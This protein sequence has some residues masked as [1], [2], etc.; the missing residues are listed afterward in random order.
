MQLE[1]ATEIGD[2]GEMCAVQHIH[3]W[4]HLHTPLVEPRV[5]VGDE[6]K[7]ERACV[8]SVETEGVVGAIHV[9]FDK[10]SEVFSLS[11]ELADVF[12]K[13]IFTHPYHLLLD[14]GISRG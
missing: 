5:R 13:N 10:V 9:G 11:D 2:S 8:S 14:H 3:A 6:T 12:A 1:R 7:H 4:R